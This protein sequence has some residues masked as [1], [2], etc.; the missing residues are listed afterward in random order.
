MRTA[1]I[2]S[3]L[4]NYSIEQDCDGDGEFANSMKNDLESYINKISRGL[5]S[6]KITNEPTK[7]ITS[8]L[9]SGTAGLYSPCSITQNYF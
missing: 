8:D 5:T 1:N 6:D 2:V 9:F 3:K 7:T 4:L